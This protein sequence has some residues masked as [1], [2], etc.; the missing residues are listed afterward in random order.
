MTLSSNPQKNAS[1]CEA[2]IFCLIPLLSQAMVDF[3]E[4]SLVLADF[5][6][7]LPRPAINHWAT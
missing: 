4:K 7:L 5:V 2:G 1:F 6:A 3:T